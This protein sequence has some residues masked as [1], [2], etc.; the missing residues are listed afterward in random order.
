[1]TALMNDVCVQMEKSGAGL[2]W[3]SGRRDRYARFGFEVAGTNLSSGIAPFCVGEPEAGWNVEQVAASQLPR[4]WTLRNRAAV[5]EEVS[6]EKWVTRLMRGGKTH[7]VFL[8]SRGRDAEAFCV[9]QAEPGEGLLEWAGANAGI[10]AIL[11]HAL[12]T[13][14]RVRV[15]YAPACVD[16]AA[17]LFWNAAEWCGTS[18]ACLR[19]LNFAA[20]LKSYAPLLEKRVPAGAGVKLS[21]EGADSAQLGVASGD[22]LPLDRLTMTRV[23]F[24]P[25]APSAVVALPEKLR[26]L[27]QV[28]PLPFMLPQSSHV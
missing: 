24:G 14:K 13:Q 5:C 23:M 3:L 19:I 26:W 4:F 18:V 9:M 8:A 10:H 27:D 15:E 20:L 25:L 7:R 16:P 28:F 2:A 1:M 11:A 17:K 6:P 21:I 22:E 12:K